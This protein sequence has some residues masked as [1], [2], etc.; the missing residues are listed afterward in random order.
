[1]LGID[2]LSLRGRQIYATI[3]FDLESGRAVDMAEGRDAQ[4]LANWLLAHPGVEIIARDRAE[5]YA[6]GPRIDASQ[7]VQVADRFHL[8]RNAS[9]ALDAML[10]NQRLQL[11]PSP[12]QPVAPA[13][14]ESRAPPEASEGA[15]VE[16]GPGPLSPTKQY[17]AERRAA[18]I[19]RWERVTSLRAAGSSIS[20]IAREAGITRR[21]VRH[22]L[23]APSPP[24]NKVER[25]RPGGLRSPMLQP[26]VPYLQDRWQ[27]GC[28]NVAQLLREI[29]GL[30]Y[31]GSRSLLAQALE[32][33]RPARLP[34][35]EAKRQRRMTR[36]L[37][38]RWLCLRPPKSLKAEE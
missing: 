18:R 2:D 11:D 4:T 5:S 35:K 3:F 20:A 17:Q 23:E 6:E 28:T 33:W 24:R 1:M 15:P 29:R 31:P 16:V 7:A 10:R 32:D 13:T 12:E 30:G 38:M 26:Y 27:T 14:T 25:P 21:T 19:A 22:L 8:L 36:R 34:R 9:D 37:S